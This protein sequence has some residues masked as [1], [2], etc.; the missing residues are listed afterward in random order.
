MAQNPVVAFCCICWLH[1]VALGVVQGGPEPNCC[2]VPLR[3]TGSLYDPSG[4]KPCCCILLHLLVAFC[5]I[6][7]GP[8]WPRTPLI[9]T[10]TE[11]LNLER[12]QND[13]ES[14]I[15][16][17]E[18]NVF[19]PEKPEIFAKK[20]TNKVRRVNRKCESYSDT[21]SES[22]EDGDS[23]DTELEKSMGGQ[24]GRGFNHDERHKII[25]STVTRS[26]RTSRP[27]E[28]FEANILESMQIR[29]QLQ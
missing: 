18:E 23:S 5:C 29:H 14:D 15:S 13:G 2:W 9:P 21:D 27:P 11:E 6:G 16:S 26:G 8:R 22:S 4:L 7:V 19:W 10:T 12:E 28:R 24:L 25:A 17:D 3:P 20:R 1:V